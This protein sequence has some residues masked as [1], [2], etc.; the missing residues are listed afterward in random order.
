MKYRRLT[1][2]QLEALEKEFIEFLVVNGITA[3]DWQKIKDKDS[4]KAN[5]FIDLFSDVVFE[6]IMRKVEYILWQSPKEIR[7]FQCLS[8]KMVLV[9]MKVGED[10]S[11][12]LT[13]TDEISQAMK[14][15]PENIQIYTTDKAYTDARE[16]ELFQMLENGSFISD[17]KIF[18]ALALAL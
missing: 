15:P 13:N 11:I 10:S 6:S 4:E 9:G 17:G 5:K 12:D 18:K 1:G 16:S 2:E 14:N 7:A 8:E 3:D